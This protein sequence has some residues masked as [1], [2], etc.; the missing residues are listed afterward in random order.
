MEL[1]FIWPGT[2]LS[3][4]PATPLRLRRDQPKS[5]S[6]VPPRAIKHIW[7]AIA[8]REQ[9]FDFGVL[10]AWRVGSLSAPIGDHT[11]ILPRS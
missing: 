5:C 2:P 6:S 4:M 9:V 8:R 11:T 10:F 3:N 7:P 1:A